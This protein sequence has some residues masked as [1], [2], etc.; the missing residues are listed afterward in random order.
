MD[1]IRLRA[2]VA[3]PLA[4]L[5]LVLLLCALAMR[6]PASAGI[7]VLMTRVREIPSENCFSGLSD[8]DIV[9]RIKDDGNIWINETQ[10]K[11]EKIRSIMSRIYESRAERIA[12]LLVDPRVSYEEFAEVYS[13][14]AS[15][16]PDL[17]IGLLTRQIRDQVEHC[18]P[19]RGC[20][21]EWAHEPGNIYCKNLFS[22]VPL[23]VLR[24]PAR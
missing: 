18:P 20:T 9:L 13:L 22:P 7:N 24:D 16:T 17:H 10:E 2:L 11:R 15:S 21:I 3:A 12:Y 8:R 19:G 1:L 4:S 23:R 5:L 14:A 6:R